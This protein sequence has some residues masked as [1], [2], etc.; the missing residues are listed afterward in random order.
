MAL[1]L[2]AQA[3]KN[4]SRTPTGQRLESDTKTLKIGG[5]CDFQL[6]PSI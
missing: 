3:I 6:S 2:N 1:P 5:F 4:S